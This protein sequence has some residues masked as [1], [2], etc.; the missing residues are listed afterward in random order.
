MKILYVSTSMGLGG[1]DMQVLSLA[2]GMRRRG[3]EVQILSFAPPGPVA[4]LAAQDGLDVQ[5]LNIRGRAG[6]LRAV[7]GV[8]RASARVRPDVLHSHLVHAN[9]LARLSRL[10]CPVPALISTGHSVREGGRWSL[11]AYRLT[12]G[13]CDLTTSVSRLALQRYLDT[14]AAPAGKLRYVANGLDLAAFDRA[15]CDRAPHDRPAHDQPAMSVDSG[16]DAPS[17]G[18][19]GPFSWIAVGRFEEAKDYPTMLRAFAQASADWPGARL[20]IVGEGRGLEA[21]RAQAQA[22]GLAQRVRFLGA[23]QD[24]PALL[25]G[26]D[27]YLMASAW[28]GLPMV[29]LEAGAARLPV[30]STAVG[31]V[32]D[33]VLH[34][35]SGLLVPP[36][37]PAALA[38]AMARLMAIPAHD[39]TQ[40]G[41]AARDHIERHFGLDSVL[42]DWEE[43]YAGV[44]RRRQTP[45]GSQE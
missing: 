37:D 42:N 13:L 9:L 12:D 31:S 25:A 14:R 1:A 32:P 20:D 19:A 10:L 41:E 33:A 39:R 11:Q 34:E 17:T 6:L 24:V 35:R 28:E 43:I 8:A 45:A 5:S 7:L 23:R 44:L 21:A 15:T 26:A 22:L 40:M 3:H 16:S 29:L 36:N 2:R 30:V 18:R 38:A 27:G 4:Q